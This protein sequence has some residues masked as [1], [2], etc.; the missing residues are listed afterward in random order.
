M[1]HEKKKQS[2][3][4]WKGKRDQHEKKQP[5]GPDTDRHKNKNNCND[6]AQKKRDR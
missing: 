6:S 2:T 1:T 3:G 5:Q 4:S